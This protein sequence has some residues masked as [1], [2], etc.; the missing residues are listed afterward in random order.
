MSQILEESQVRA[1]VAEYL[2]PIKKRIDQAKQDRGRFEPTWHQN[3]AFGAGKYWHKWSRSGHRL[4]LDPRDV[5]H[6]KERLTID[7]L[8]QNLWTA[9]GQ[10]AGAEQRRNLLFRREDIPSEE[11]TKT[12]NSALAYGWDYEWRAADKLAQIKRKLIID[13][14]AAIQCYFDPTVG[15]ELGEMPVKDGQA[16]YD[17]EKARAYMAE[18]AV[19]GR[20]PQ[21]RAIREGRI[22]WHPRSVFALLVP[23]SVEDE[24]LFPWEAIVEAVSIDKLIERYGDRAKGLKEEPLAALEQLGIKDTIEVGFEN[25]PDSDT[26][27][28]GKLDGY[29]A[30]ITYFERPSTKYARGRVITYAGDKL[31]EEPRLE[32]PYKRPNSDYHSGIVYFHY[33]RIEG[34]FWG[35]GLIEPGKGIQRTYNKRLQQEAITIDRGQPY[36]LADEQSNIKQTETPLEVVRYQSGGTPAPQAVSGVPVHESLW[37]SKDGLKED[38]QTAMGIHAV[39]TGEAPTRE[40]TFAELNLRAEKDR[41]KLD[42]IFEDFQGAVATLTELSV[43]DIRNYWPQDKLM[44]IAGEEGHAEAIQ[45]QAEKLPEFF[46]T[47]LSDSAKPRSDAASIQLVMDLWRA[48]KEEA[49]ATGQPP[50]LD[51]GWLKGSL[52][53]GKPLDFPESQ[54]DIQTQKARWENSRMLAGDL[55]KPL[56]YDDPAVHIPIHREAQIEAEMAY[57]EETWHIFEAHI[58]ETMQLAD[59]L[60]TLAA[61]EEAESQ[62]NLEDAVGQQ[63]AQAGEQAAESEHARQLELQ[64][65]QQKAKAKEKKP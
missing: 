57:D 6:G 34:R 23:P 11:F 62:A 36:V 45:F 49:A 27:S 22:C 43:Y 59:L 18:E 8:T 38:L 2:D 7:I 20:R 50:N 28:P 14:T 35:R 16:V 33:W 63:E 47:E 3:R 30:K 17:G 40:T 56:E 32:L 9:L 21:L 5:E 54:K 31:L 24:E 42:P 12:A 44:A 19:E 26:G 46:L 61:K 1:S 25:E 52:E 65:Q 51:L 55:P 29:V 48:D 39:S 64:D 13:G 10:L 60:A 4:R 41:V 53:A 37:R 15:K 58:A